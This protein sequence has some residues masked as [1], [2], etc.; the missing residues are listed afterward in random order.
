M[1]KNESNVPL[2]GTLFD[3][4]LNTAPKLSNVRANRYV[5]DIEQI[6][7]QIEPLPNEVE[8]SGWVGAV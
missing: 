7:V 3:T 1:T 8:V 4:P 5:R 2:M 6:R